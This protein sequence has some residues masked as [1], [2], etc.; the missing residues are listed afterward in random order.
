MSNVLSFSNCNILMSHIPKDTSMKKN[1]IIE[2]VRNSFE[3]LNHCILSMYKYSLLHILRPV[4]SCTRLGINNIP[5]LL[6]SC[7][8]NM[9]DKIIFQFLYGVISM[10]CGFTTLHH[11]HLHNWLQKRFHTT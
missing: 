2:P 7:I 8:F 11:V 4:F 6:L 5:A 9:L 10:K 1:G 3:Q